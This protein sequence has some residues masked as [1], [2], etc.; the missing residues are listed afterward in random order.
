MSFTDFFNYS[1]SSTLGLSV[2]KWQSKDG[3]W[4]YDI[5][6]AYFVVEVKSK[7][8]CEIGKSLWPHLINICFLVNLIDHF[9]KFRSTYNVFRSVIPVFCW[10]SKH[11]S[12]RPGNG[13]KD[14][15]IM[16]HK[17]IN[18]AAKQH[19]EIFFI[20]FRFSKYQTKNFNIFGLI[21]WIW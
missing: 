1:I 17:K 21:I 4:K 15:T 5:L 11:I 12:G 8:T 14:I 6:F 18:R 20:I 7:K 3:F 2:N 19:I 16:L 13:A 10:H 9:P